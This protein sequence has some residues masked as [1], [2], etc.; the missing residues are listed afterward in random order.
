MEQK[1][2]FHNNCEMHSIASFKLI[3]MENMAW[4]SN[5]IEERY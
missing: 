4:A 1:F 2:A 3:W 5:D